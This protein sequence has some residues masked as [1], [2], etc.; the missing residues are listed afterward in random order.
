VREETY[1]YDKNYYCYLGGRWFHAATMAGPWDALSMKYVPVAIYR[2]RGHLP[3]E[4]E[5]QAHDERKRTLIS[6]ASFSVGDTAESK[7][8]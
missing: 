4:L 2:V 8:R 7:Q 5:Q 1:C 3:P 6:L